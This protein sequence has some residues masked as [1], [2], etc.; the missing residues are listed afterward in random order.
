MEK[1]MRSYKSQYLADSI[2]N[3]Q[4]EPL[5]KRSNVMHKIQILVV[6][7]TLCVLG[8][9]GCQKAIEPIAVDQPVDSDYALLERAYCPAPDN[10]PPSPIVTVTAGQKS[11]DFWPF[12]G[13]NFAGQPQD[14]INI[15]FVGKADPR[16]IRAALMSLNGDRTSFGYP[17]AAPF[18]STWEDA[19]GDVQTGYSS[20]NG[21]TGG[22]IQL[23]CG[24]YQQARFHIRLFKMGEWTVGNGHFEV[25]IPGTTDHQVLSWEKAEQFVMVDFLRS[26]LL[27]PSA[28]IIPTGPINPSPFRTIPSIIYNGL[29]VEVR[30][31][32]EGPL[33]NVS[34]DVPIGTDGGA[35]IF[36]LAGSVPR[37][38]GV[39]VQ[40]FV[41]NFNQV[42]PK[43]FCSSGPY[44][45]LFVQGPVHLV[46]T[47]SLTANGTYKFDFVA[48][49]ELTAVPVNPMTG[50]PTG[51]PITGIVLESHSGMLQDGYAAALSSKYQKLGSWKE[52]SGG[53]LYT[54]LIVRSNGLNGFT[55]TI[56][57]AE[58]DGT[59]ANVN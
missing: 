20:G 12:T 32:I 10:P 38:A 51:A 1:N 35:L 25:L 24:D 13:T 16:D 54:R 57:C 2:N 6:I 46:Q 41:I 44:D 3:Q 50:E 29:P 58:T 47:T 37:Q 55:E 59:V 28:P 52:S 15:I 14:P 22:V 21:W 8:T 9:I 45:Y 7:L 33:G 17:P 36:N 53:L 43:P 49:A 56:K 40:D 18:N 11:L 23:A 34:E 19:I 26:G 48:N 4:T 42:I 5:L 39:K 27:D 30:G 31:F